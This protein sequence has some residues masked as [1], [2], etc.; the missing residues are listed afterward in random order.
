MA[1]VPQTTATDPLDVLRAFGRQYPCPA[2]AEIE[3]LRNVLRMATDGTFEMP[4]GSFA[5]AARAALKGRRLPR[6]GA[7]VTDEDARWFEDAD[8]G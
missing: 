2:V 3:R 4:D 5:S 6:R 8:H 7:I 1:E